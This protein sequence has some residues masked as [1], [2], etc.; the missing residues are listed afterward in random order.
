MEF[1]DFSWHL[2]ETKVGRFAA[3]LASGKIMATRCT[4]CMTKFYPPR[5]DCSNCLSSEMDWM[6][7]NGRGRLVT[8][9]MIH[10]P[11]ERFSPTSPMPFS[12]ITFQPCPIGL[13]EVEDGLRIMGWMPNVRPEDIRVGIPLQA[14]P[15]TLTDGRVT[16]ILE[17]IDSKPKRETASP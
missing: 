16:I 13:L 2:N 12:S 3:E 1:K 8:F 17:P 5:A 10:V 9:T 7:L 6:A 14:T 15:H 4:A 11:P